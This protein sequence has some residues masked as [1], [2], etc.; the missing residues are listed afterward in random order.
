MEEARKK[1]RAEN[2]NQRAQSDLIKDHGCINEK[3][4]FK[5][6]Q[7]KKLL[8]GSKPRKRREES[9]KENRKKN[10]KEKKG[11]FRKS[12]KSQSKE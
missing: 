8:H 6:K 4:G 7:K 1:A 5:E 3:I 9:Q 10:R 11:H 12:G 2:Q